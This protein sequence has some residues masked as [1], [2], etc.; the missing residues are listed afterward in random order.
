MSV[1][2]YYAE[3]KKEQWREVAKYVNTNAH[4]RDMLLFNAYYCMEPFNYY[5]RSDLAK[6][7]FPESDRTV[8]EKNINTLWK[9]VKHYDRVWVILSHSGD[10]KELITKTLMKS[11]RLSSQAEFKFIKIYLFEKGSGKTA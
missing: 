11:Y 10:K 2:G 3:I 5:S 1:R 6:K 8:D 4:S 7:G 9:T